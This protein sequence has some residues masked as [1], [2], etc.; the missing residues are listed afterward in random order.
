M[1]HSAAQLLDAEPGDIEGRDEQHVA[2]RRP[3]KSGY[4]TTCVRR[5]RPF[6]VGLALAISCAGTAGGQTASIPGAG[7]TMSNASI[8]WQAKEKR[9]CRHGVSFD[10]ITKSEPSWRRRSTSIKIGPTMS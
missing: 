4:G 10:N 8:A 9:R 6:E 3:E 7:A 5:S 1:S 2:E